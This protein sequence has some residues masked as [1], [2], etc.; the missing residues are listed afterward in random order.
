MIV[1]VF[2]DIIDAV[3][4]K[5]KPEKVGPSN[6]GIDR[7][8]MAAAF[9]A[10]LQHMND[11]AVARAL[12][13]EYVLPTRAF[14]C[15]ASGRRT[16]GSAASLVYPT[17]FPAPGRRRRGALPL[18]DQLRGAAGRPRNGACPRSGWL[19]FFCMPEWPY[20]PAVLHVN[21]PCRPRSGPEAG[22]AEWFQ[23]RERDAP[24]HRRLPAWAVN[25]RSGMN[26]CPRSAATCRAMRR[27]CDTR[28]RGRSSH[29]PIRPSG[30]GTT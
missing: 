28:G 17:T 6:A 3:R 27:G 2:R 16:A 4:K 15:A 12:P 9:R 26:L 30:R 22:D 13:P 24:L 10:Q 19:V 20:R 8:E 5:R 14:P 7:A 11:L 29:W 1:T 18:P 25:L 21:D 23:P